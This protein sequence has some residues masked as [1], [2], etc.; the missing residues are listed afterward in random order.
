MIGLL[1]ALMIIGLVLMIG[2]ISLALLQ[3]LKELRVIKRALTT[4][5]GTSECFVDQYVYG[6]KNHQ[7]A[8]PR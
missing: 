1:F 6:D 3:L 2:T 7:K 4:L 8:D 5:V